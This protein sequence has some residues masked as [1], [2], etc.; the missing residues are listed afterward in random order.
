MKKISILLYILLL[1]PYSFGYTLQ[2]SYIERPPYY[3]TKNHK[4]TGFLL[5]LQKKIFDDADINVQFVSLPAKRALKRVKNPSNQHCSIGWFKTTKR[6][7]F[8][9]FTRPI[10]QN[11]PLFLVIKKKNSSLFKKY[12]T[13]KEVFLNK[14]LSF[15]KIDGFSYG[16]I[17]DELIKNLSPKF[18]TITGEQQQLIRMLNKE[19]MTYILVAPEEIEMLLKSNRLDSDD[20]KFINLTDIPFGNK[21]YLM[22]SKGVKKEVINNINKSRTVYI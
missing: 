11:K 21:R 2:V 6:K 1:T 7:K 12:T 13:L 4:P 17:V 10:Y 15:A 9:N 3:F 14:T 19:R 16:I 18:Y 22:C 20:F 8:A 5:D